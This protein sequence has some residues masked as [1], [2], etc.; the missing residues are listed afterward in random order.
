MADYD[1]IIAGDTTHDGHLDV[2]VE[3]TTGDGDF[4][5]KLETRKK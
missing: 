5:A 2:I 3:D 1:V 4:D